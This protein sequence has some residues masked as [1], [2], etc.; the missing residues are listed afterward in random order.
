[1]IEHFER[2][3]SIYPRKVAKGQAKKTWGKMVKGMTDAEEHEFADLLVG[4]INAQKKGRQEHDRT[5]QFV[6]PWK[7]PTTWLNGECWND[8]IKSIQEIREESNVQNPACHCGHKSFITTQKQW[9]CCWHY[10]EKHCNNG[11]TGLNVLRQ[12]YKNREPRLPGETGLAYLSRVYGRRKRVSVEPDKNL[13][14]E[15]E[16][17]PESVDDGAWSAEKC[18]REMEKPAWKKLPTQRS[19]SGGGGMMR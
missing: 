1:M 4:A 10:S 15:P 7:H 16:S 19:S 18:Q 12:A 5:G 2:F 3:W 9:L 13:I 11:T 8:E 17:I 6:P 14:P